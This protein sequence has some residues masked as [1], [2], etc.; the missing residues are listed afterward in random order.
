MYAKLYLHVAL[1]ADRTD[2]EDL[3]D[4]THLVPKGKA[5]MSLNVNKAQFK[6]LQCH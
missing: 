3:E 2:M 5:I 4:M 6:S 1:M